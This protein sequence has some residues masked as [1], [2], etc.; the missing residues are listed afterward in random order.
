M[1]PISPSSTSSS[2]SSLFSDSENSPQVIIRRPSDSLNASPYP[3]GIQVTTPVIVTPVEQRI[4][5]NIRHGNGMRRIRR[6][7][8]FVLDSIRRRLSMATAGEQQIETNS[9]R[10][11]PRSKTTEKTWTAIELKSP[12]PFHVILS[13]ILKNHDISPHSIEAPPPPTPLN[14]SKLR[15]INRLESIELGIMTLERS[16]EEEEIEKAIDL[17]EWNLGHVESEAASIDRILFDI[18]DEAQRKS[19]KWKNIE[20]IMNLIREDES[21]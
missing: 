15:E 8:E 12:D 14:P 16:R 21:L 6:R 13:E 11:L 1:D 3:R 18:E 4:P 19:K 10:T 17:L 7:Q 20:L 5:R 9:P 2:T